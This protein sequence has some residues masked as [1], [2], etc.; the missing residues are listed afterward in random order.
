VIL[1]RLSN[2]SIPLVCAKGYAE[3]VAVL[4]THQPKQSSQVYGIMVLIYFVEKTKNYFM[5][6]PYSHWEDAFPLGRFSA[7]MYP[8]FLA[9][10][11][12]I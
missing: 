11:M 10:S 4:A 8:P 12:V 7:G 6:K 5:Q 2:A 9:G 1:L 3:A